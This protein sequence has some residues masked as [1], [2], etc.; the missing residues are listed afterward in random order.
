VNAAIYAFVARIDDEREIVAEL[1]EKKVAQ[2][3]YTQAL[4]QGHGAYLLEQ[5]EASKDVFIVSVG[6]YVIVF[7]LGNKYRILFSDVIL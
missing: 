3:E 1:K 5:D 6:A 4:A 7:L 2:Q